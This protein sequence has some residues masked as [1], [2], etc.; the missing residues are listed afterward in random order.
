VSW[1]HF[2]EFAVNTTA[3]GT[4]SFWHSMREKKVFIERW[5]I[6]LMRL[7]RRDDALKKYNKKL[8]PKTARAICGRRCCCCCWRCNIFTATRPCPN[9]ISRKCK[10]TRC[11]SAHYKFF[12]RHSREPISGTVIN[13]RARRE[14]RFACSAARWQG[15]NSGALS[16][17]CARR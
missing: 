15:I 11:A 8:G 16:E 2:Q 1:Q 17:K 9:L 7:F 12:T 4:I 5:A 13:W 14:C 10:H 6:Q 3:Q